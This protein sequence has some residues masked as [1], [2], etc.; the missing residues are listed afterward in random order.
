LFYYLFRPISSLYDGIAAVLA[1]LQTK[2]RHACVPT[3]LK[4]L[5]VL[6]QNERFE[7]PDVIVSKCG[8]SR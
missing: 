6:I 5:S 2:D 4:P 3:E 1:V 7:L 8:C